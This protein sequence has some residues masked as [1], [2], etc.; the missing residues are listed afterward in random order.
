MTTFSFSDLE[1]IWTNNGG[2]SV[3]API[4]AAIAMAESGGNSDAIGHNS[5]GSVDQGLWQINSSN[6]A[7]STTDINGN[8]RAAIQMSN[9]G[10][11]WRPWCTAYSDG[12]CGTKGGT[13]L[14]TGAP[15]QK[16][17]SGQSQIP[18]GQSAIGGSTDATLTAQT[19]AD[20]VFPSGG[21]IHVHLPLYTQTIS[22]CFWYDSWSRA[23]L[24]GL[25]FLGAGALTIVGV[26]L[27]ASR[28]QVGRQATKMAAKLGIAGALL[29]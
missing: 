10:T 29:A 25:F 24:G 28:T 3:F 5:N 23:F 13:F 17:L 4:A 7:L 11:N 26:S 22:M 18:Q 6:G 19:K 27:L 9:D 12:A 20:C 16:F 14:G 15:Y 21:A 2:S 1:Q 8:A